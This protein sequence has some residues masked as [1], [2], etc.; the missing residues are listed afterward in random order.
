MND[1]GVGDS[2][3]IVA[4]IIAVIIIVAVYAIGNSGN[5]GYVG[6]T[7]IEQPVN[8]GNGVYYFPVINA[9]FANSL[10]AFL[11]E[12]GNVTIVTIAG[13]GTGA[14][15]YDKGYFVVIK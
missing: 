13:D 10:S 6:K 5:T 15:G 3:I 8:Y 7:S 9:E 12:H 11:K 1:R 14:Y 2:I 4:V